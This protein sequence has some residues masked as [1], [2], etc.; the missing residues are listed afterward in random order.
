M[1]DAERA[2]SAINTNNL[3]WNGPQVMSDAATVLSSGK[4]LAGHPQMYAPNPLESGSSVSHWNTT[5]FPNQLMEPAINGDLTHSVMPPQDLTLSLLR[6]IGWCSGCPDLTPSPCPPP[7]PNND[8][9]NSQ[10]ISGCSGSALGTNLAANKELGEPSHSPDGDPGGG[11]VW[12]QWQAPGS[13]SVTMTTAGSNYDTLLGVYTGNSVGGL[14]LI[15]RN[16]DVGTPGVLT[17]SVTFTATAGTIYKIAVDGWGGAVGNITLDWTSS[18]C[19]P[20][21]INSVMPQVG[22]TSGGQQVKLFGP[23]ANV[24]SVMVGGVSAAWSYTNGTSEITLTTPPHSVGAVNIDIVPTVGSTYTKSNGFAYLPTVFTDDTLV[25]GVTTAKAQHVI[26]L[27]QAIDALRAVAG[28]A[29]V[30]WVD[31]TVSPASTIIKA[32]HLLE[33]RTNLDNVLTIL[34]LSTLPYTDPALTT[35]FSLKRV[36]IEELRQR[37]RNI[38]DDGIPP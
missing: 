38:V 21:T 24:S 2:A 4:D 11:S 30:A 3:V 10:I 33:L 31:S 6:D 16:D 26:E 28:L 18:S 14:T 35:G 29:P 36:H 23:F 19:P 27:R 37:I 5:A 13:G 7:P 32:V 22:R 15:G 1:T 12:Y 8:F 17:S 25:V 9:I 20:N 34:G